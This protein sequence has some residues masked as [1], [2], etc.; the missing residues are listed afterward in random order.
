MK[1]HTEDLGTGSLRFMQKPAKKKG[2]LHKTIYFVFNFTKYVA[3]IL[4][5]NLFKYSLWKSV[6]TSCQK[7]NDKIYSVHVVVLSI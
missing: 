6:F 5:T 7:F 3:Y 4:V 1:S 2:L